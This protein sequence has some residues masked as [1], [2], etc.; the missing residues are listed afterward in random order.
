LGSTG[1]PAPRSKPRIAATLFKRLIKYSQKCSKRC[2]GLEGDGTADPG[3]ARQAGVVDRSRCALSA[4]RRSPPWSG[5]RV[6]RPQGVG[7]P[8]GPLGVRLGSILAIGSH[9]ESR[10]WSGSGPGRLEA[11]V[12]K[13]RRGWVPVIAPTSR[14]RPETTNDCCPTRSQYVGHPFWKRRQRVSM[15]P[16][17]QRTSIG[18]ERT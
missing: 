17:E 15:T 11:D 14:A 4:A 12:P 8:E 3:R 16:D 5:S 2:F 1:L 18:G 6:H 7:L 9:P 10:R 13:V